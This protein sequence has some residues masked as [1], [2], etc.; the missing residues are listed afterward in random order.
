MPRSSAATVKRRSPTAGTT[1][2]CGGGDLVREVG[3]DHL[4]AGEHPLERVDAG[5]VAGEDADPHRAA[6][7]QVP[8]ERAGVDAGDADDALRRRARR[9]ATRRLRQDEETRDGSRTT[10]PATQIRRGLRV[11]VVDAGVADLRGGH[12][13]DLAV[14]ARVGERLLVAGHAGVEDGLAEGLADGAV[15][16]AAEGAAVLEHEQG[17]AVIATP[18]GGRPAACAGRRRRAGGAGRGRR[19]G[20]PDCSGPAAEP[21]GEQQQAVLADDL[22][23]EGVARGRASSDVGRT[24]GTGR[25]GPRAR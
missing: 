14:V 23:G 11:L 10:K 8:G 5:D 19:R 7:A 6:L 20:R 12:D 4:R 3:A 15:G 1:Y 24:A 17:G 16:L 21:P 2:G 22:A 9:R 13:D 25:A 18:P